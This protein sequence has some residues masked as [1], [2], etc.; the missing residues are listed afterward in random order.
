MIYY[1]FREYIGRRITFKTVY[2]K[3]EEDRFMKLSEAIE[4]VTLKG[5]ALYY[6][7]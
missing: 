2:S 7:R 6:R 4:T 3:E 1:H 5:N